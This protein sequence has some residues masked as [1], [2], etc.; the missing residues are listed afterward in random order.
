MSYMWTHA[1]HA[2]TLILVAI[3]IKTIIAI[4]IKCVCIYVFQARN[5]EA[6]HNFWL[7]TK[8]SLKAKYWRVERVC[9]NGFAQFGAA[10]N[11]SD[12]MFMSKC[13]HFYFQI[14]LYVY[15]GMRVK[16]CVWYCLLFCVF[17][18]NG[19]H[20]FYIIYS[21]YN[22]LLIECDRHIFYNTQLFNFHVF[23]SRKK[24]EWAKIVKSTQLLLS[25]L[26]ILSSHICQ[27]E[28]LR[29]WLKLIY[30]RASVARMRT[31]IDC[32]RQCLK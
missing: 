5:I 4:I 2:Q 29:L 18:T 21:T 19:V 6:S 24:S 20:P 32:G 8:C 16:S 11:V 31:K 15:I 3:V 28:P 14:S 1:K 13:I 25:S 7:R 27:L 17:S 9:T 30:A 23:L 26:S 10:I 12:S 22:I